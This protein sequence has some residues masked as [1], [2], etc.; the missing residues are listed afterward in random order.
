MPCGLV[1]G[2]FCVYIYGNP[3]KSME[4]RVEL[5]DRHSKIEFATE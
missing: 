2:R 4:I 3:W 1:F 5:Q